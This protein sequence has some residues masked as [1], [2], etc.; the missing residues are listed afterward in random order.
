MERISTLFR[1][2]PALAKTRPNSDEFKGDGLFLYLTMTVIYIPTA[3]KAKI[4]F[5]KAQIQQ[6]SF[7]T[8]YSKK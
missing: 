2:S 7:P 3:I 8:I 4:C 1:G 5:P 6:F